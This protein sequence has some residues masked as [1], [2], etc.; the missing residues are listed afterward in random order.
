MVCRVNPH[1]SPEATTVQAAWATSNLPR[2]A[3]CRTRRCPLPTFDRSNMPKTAFRQ[4]PQ[5]AWLWADSIEISR[6]SRVNCVAFMASACFMREE[7]PAASTT[8]GRF[9]GDQGAQH[10]PRPTPKV[11]EA[12]APAMRTASC[13]CDAWRAGTQASPHP[14]L[15]T[16]P[17][18]IPWPRRHRR[19]AQPFKL[20][21]AEPQSVPQLGMVLGHPLWHIGMVRPI[22][23]CDG[24]QPLVFPSCA[25]HVLLFVRQ[26]IPS[27]EFHWRTPSATVL[28]NQGQSI[29]FAS[30]RGWLRVSLGSPESTT[31]QTPSP[32]RS[33]RSTFQS[34]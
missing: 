33:K 31:T 17:P 2:R 4:S 34:E 6:S 9:G 3:Q 5:G 8:A 32:E 1:A 26:L 10:A 30:G 15:L 11:Q 20:R 12:A 19:F 28:G 16:R 7:R 23:S 22:L 13:T 24:F 29:R 25:P 14:L 18:S 21:S 27:R